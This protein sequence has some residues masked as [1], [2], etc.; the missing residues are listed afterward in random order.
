MPI[1]SYIVICTKKELLAPSVYELRF[2]KPEGFSFKAGQF[3]LFDVPL[4]NNP[5]DIQTRAYSLA[6]SPEE[7][8]LVFVIKLKEGGRGSI[9][10]EEEIGVGSKVRMQGPFGLFLLRDADTSYILAATGAG[11]APFRSQA[12]WLLEE[13][14]DTRPLTVLFGVRDPQD[15]FW[16]EEFERLAA[17]FPHFTFLPILSGTSPSWT[18]LRGRVQTHLAP[19]VKVGAGIYICGAPEMVKDV[20]E[21]CVGPLG[22]QKSQVHAEGYI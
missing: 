9:W 2:G 8:E 3:V 5:K 12:K 18:G 17:S 14:G 21:T 1:P 6:S 15:F 10:I 13:K 16:I 20:K 11:I 7:K 19:L 22:L 4:K